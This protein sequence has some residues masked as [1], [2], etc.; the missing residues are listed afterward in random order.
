MKKQENGFS[1]VEA[2]LIVIIV[3]MLAGVG[4]YVWHA[5]SQANSVLDKADV[6]AQNA[7]TVGSKKTSSTQKEITIKE[8]GVKGKTSTTLNLEYVMSDDA[9]IAGFSSK[10]LDASDSIC[11]GGH[12]GGSIVREKSGEEHHDGDDGAGTGQKASVYAKTLKTGDYGQ[13]GDY[14]Y[15]YKGV[16]AACSK[17]KTS[18][19]L[20]G[21][22][23]SAVLE[24]LSSLKAEE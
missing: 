2:L 13:V 11:K 8:W 16:Q 20:Q 15:F 23:H 4:W 3:G 17:A 7:Q 18:Q 9:I 5:N 21:D 1:A 6:T 10:E 14:L 19:D 22:T 24:L 12:Y